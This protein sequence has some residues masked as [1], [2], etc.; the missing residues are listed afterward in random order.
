MT[1]ANPQDDRLQDLQKQGAI[2]PGKEAVEKTATVFDDYTEHSFWTGFWIGFCLGCI[3][4]TLVI[5]FAFW[6][7]NDISILNFPVPK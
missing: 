6:W 4:T 5:G 2:A 3:I 1:P 7:I